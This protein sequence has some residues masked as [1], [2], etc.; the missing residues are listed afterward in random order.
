MVMNDVD[1]DDDDDDD[2][3]DDGWQRKVQPQLIIN[4][5]LPPAQSKQLSNSI[6]SLLVYTRVVFLQF[7]T[8]SS[9]FKNSWNPSD[10]PATIRNYPCLS[11][12]TTVAAKPALGEKMKGDL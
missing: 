12:N 8:S 4:V 1:D 11:I 10:Y 6:T 5:E 3:D 7:Y 2:G 9:A